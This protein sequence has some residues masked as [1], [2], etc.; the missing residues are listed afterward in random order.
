MKVTFGNVDVGVVPLLSL[1]AFFLS[2]TVL[3]VSGMTRVR[4]KTAPTMMNRTQ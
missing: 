3:N 2:M 1:A 4:A